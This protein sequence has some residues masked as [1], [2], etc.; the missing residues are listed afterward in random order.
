M[1]TLKMTFDIR[2]FIGVMGHNFSPASFS[3][4]KAPPPPATASS[5]RVNGRHGEMVEGLIE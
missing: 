5:D 1:K 2:G 3:R 4:S